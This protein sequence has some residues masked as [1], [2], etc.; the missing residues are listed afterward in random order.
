MAARRGA[1]L[2]LAAGLAVGAGMAG[3][4]A[5]S[6]DLELYARLLQRYTRAVPDIAGTRVDYAGLRRSAQ[7]RQLVAGLASDHPEQLEGRAERL[8]YWIDV[9]NILA[10]DLVVRGH[11]ARS[12]RDLGSWWRPVWKEPAGMV[13][14]RPRTL[15]EVEHGILRP[16]GDPRVHGAIVC[17][18][19][20]CPPL[21]REPY[22]AATLDAQLDANVRRWLA[23]PR[24][25]LRV[26]Q[27]D[28]VVWLSRIFDW[29]A[30]D[31]A[32][33]GGTLAFVERYAPPADAAWIRTHAA[34]AKVRFLD[35]DWRLNA[36]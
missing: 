26:D 19:L 35:Y 7:W 23:D 33:G 29:F 32:A 21:A 27:E 17:A 3:A 4:P 14:G 20:S 1:T 15:D 9:Y 12:I 2:L 24:K 36:L 5:R 16:M 25:G 31:F 6:L 22:R 13:G 34:D 30:G 28:G 10:I 11:P 18:S 8:A